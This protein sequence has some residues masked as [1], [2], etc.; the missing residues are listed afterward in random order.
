MPFSLK[1]L[2]RLGHQKR[3][4]VSKLFRTKNRTSHHDEHTAGDQQPNGLKPVVTESHA[5]E[6]PSSETINPSSDEA[7]LSDG[8]SASD[9]EGAPCDPDDAEEQ[10]PAHLSRMT[11]ELRA[12]AEEN[13]YSDGDGD[14][15]DDVVEEVWTD[16]LVEDSDTGEELCV[17]KEDGA[18]STPD[19]PNRRLYASAS[20]SVKGVPDLRWFFSPEVDRAKEV[21]RMPPGNYPANWGLQHISCQG[22]VARWAVNKFTLEILHPWAGWGSDDVERA[23][24]KIWML[25]RDGKWSHRWDQ[26][27]DDWN[28]KVGRI[29]DDSALCAPATRRAHDRFVEAELRR[30]LGEQEEKGRGKGKEAGPD[31]AAAAVL[32]KKMF[33]GLGCTTTKAQIRSEEEENGLRPAWE[34]DAENKVFLEKCAAMNRDIEITSRIL[35][36]KRKTQA[37]PCKQPANPT[38]GGVASILQG[39][40]ITAP[41]AATGKGKGEDEEEDEE[42]DGEEEGEGA[43]NDTPACAPAGAAATIAKTWQDVRSTATDP[44]YWENL[45]GS[46]ANALQGWGSWM[47]SSR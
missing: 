32:R 22:G 38:S 29:I 3:S 12:C 7:Q 43:G 34:L 37:P 25:Q 8:D 24:F 27:I 23:L 15:K 31:S 28:H 17:S 46:T 19:E 5:V 40:A 14:E 13:P 39:S 41:D 11:E 35:E 21:D 33:L 16:V 26:D 42:E 2:R 20:S 30:W 44:A 6:Q 45:R 1:E 10:P 4:R 47:K 36:A 9:Y 18:F